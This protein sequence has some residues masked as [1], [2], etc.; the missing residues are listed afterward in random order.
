MLPSPEIEGNGRTDEED[1]E[2]KLKCEVGEN[3]PLSS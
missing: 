1:K 3:G 2:K